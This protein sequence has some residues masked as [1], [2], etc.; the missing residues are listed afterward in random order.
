MQI[1][2]IAYFSM[3]YYFTRNMESHQ[4][5]RAVC[6]HTSSYLFI[7][8][9]LVGC[10]KNPDE[11]VAKGQSDLTGK[12]KEF[13]ILFKDLD[14]SRLHIFPPIEEQ[15]LADYPFSGLEIDVH[16]FS[17]LNND[18][19]FEN[20]ESCRQ[21]QSH[22]YA[23]GKFDVDHRTIALLFRQ[24]SQYWESVIEL[25]LWDKETRS[26]SKGIELA[27]SFGDEGWYFV[28]ESWIDFKAGTDLKI[29]T[30]R[31]D[32]EFLGQT[33]RRTISDSLSQFVLRGITFTRTSISQG[34][35][36][37]YPLKHWR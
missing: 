1:M 13:L 25:V 30:R 7:L 35:T 10:E 22:I 33:D 5:L 11:N 3:I 21:G 29:I 12:A 24:H 18:D 6:M 27:D 28:M 32:S 19:I 8:L 4:N 14:P 37:L 20:I 31:K 34:D 16:K 23:V 36:M 26:I 9:L 17:Y 15:K 2:W